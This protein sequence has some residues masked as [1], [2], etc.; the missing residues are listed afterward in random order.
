MSYPYRSHFQRTLNRDG[1]N[2]AVHQD[3]NEKTGEK[4]VEE[5]KQ[6]T[7]FKEAACCF[8]A[9]VQRA[10]RRKNG[11]CEESVLDNW[12]PREGNFNPVVG[13]STTTLRRLSIGVAL[14]SSLFK[15]RLIHLQI[16][17]SSSPLLQLSHL[18]LH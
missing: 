17:S 13:N 1:M 18:T 11:L 8:S 14:N 10:E 7:D 2:V 4:K 16:I 9:I 5:R 12:D 15:T 6:S 3:K